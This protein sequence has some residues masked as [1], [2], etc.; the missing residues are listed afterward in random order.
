M[1]C[2]P[3]TVEGSV[4]PDARSITGEDSSRSICPVSGRGETHDVDLRLGVTEAWNGFT[5]VDFTEVGFFLLDGY[6]QAVFA[7]AWT[8]FAAYDFLI[9]KFDSKRLHCLVNLAPTE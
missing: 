4:K 5:P 3:G 2:Q 8:G 6:P 9:K 7:Q 1:V